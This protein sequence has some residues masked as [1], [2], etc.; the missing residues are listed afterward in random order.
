MKHKSSSVLWARGG[1]GHGIKGD[2]T[3]H[4]RLCC[5]C[6]ADG[7]DEPATQSHLAAMQSPPTKSKPVAKASASS[8]NGAPPGNPNPIVQRL[9]AFLDNH[10]YAKSPMQVGCS[11]GAVV[12]DSS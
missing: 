3:G 6:V 12:P 4:E 5:V 7:T 9:P 1:R 2:G 8:I 10:N 11:S